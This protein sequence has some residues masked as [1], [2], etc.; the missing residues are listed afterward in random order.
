MRDHRVSGLEETMYA[1]EAA[2][3]CNNEEAPEGVIS[4]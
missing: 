1:E 2:V 3:L 4:E